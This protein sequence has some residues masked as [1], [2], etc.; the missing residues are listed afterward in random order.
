MTVYCRT[1]AIP[2]VVQVM[3]VILLQGIGGVET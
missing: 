2:R 3:L 1:A